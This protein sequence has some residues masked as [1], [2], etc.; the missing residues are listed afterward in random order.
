MA[1]ND[2]PVEATVELSLADV[3]QRS[4]AARTPLDRLQHTRAL[5]AG[6]VRQRDAHELCDMVVKCTDPVSRARAAQTLGYHLAPARFPEVGDTL[7][8]RLKDEPDLIVAKSI[9]FALRSTEAAW[10]AAKSGRQ[11]VVLEALV[12]APLADSSHWE[13]ALDLYFRGVS[14]PVGEVL[15]RRFKA[16]DGAVRSIRGE[17]VGG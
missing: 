10:N 15:H 7:L 17:A 14:Q 6:R 5:K 9:V 11:A 2:D 3:V 16:A 13:R 4:S 1:G 12:G 8:R